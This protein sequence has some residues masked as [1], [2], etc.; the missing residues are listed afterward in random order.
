[1]RTDVKV[2][3]GATPLYV[4]MDRI[5]SAEPTSAIAVFRTPGGFCRA[6]FANTVTTQAAIQRGDSGLV[7]IYHK[8]MHLGD[9]RDEIVGAGGDKC[10]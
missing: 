4:I 10:L 7:G 8:H 5:K 3:P 2:E 1:M 6:V 9:V